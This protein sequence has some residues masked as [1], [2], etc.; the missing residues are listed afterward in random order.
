MGVIENRVEGE[1]ASTSKEVSRYSLDATDYVP[2][3]RH[4]ESRLIAKLLPDNIT[5]QK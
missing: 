5:R 1:I 4:H 3:I 2:S